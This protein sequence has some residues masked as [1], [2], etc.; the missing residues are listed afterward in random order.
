MVL[1]SQKDN[2]VKFNQCLKSHKRACIIYADLVSLI[3][4]LDGCANNRENSS[5]TKAGQRISCGYSMSNIW[6]FDNIENKYNLYR[7]CIKTLFIS[8]R[9]I[10]RQIEL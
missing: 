7:D 8:L 1:S 10:I 6:V 4:K 9:V 2:L 3:K 5:T